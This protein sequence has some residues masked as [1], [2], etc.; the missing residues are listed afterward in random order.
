MLEEP[1]FSLDLI[2]LEGGEAALPQP[3]DFGFLT[4]LE[5]GLTLG[6]EDGEISMKKGE[7]FFLPRAGRKLTLKGRGRAALSM[8]RGE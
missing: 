8:P 5:E 7:S 3:E 1:F 6:W 2:C 4:A